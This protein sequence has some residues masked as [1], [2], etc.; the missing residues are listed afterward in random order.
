[1]AKSPPPP[2]GAG[3]S[4]TNCT[5]HLDR[6][7]LLTCIRYERAYCHECMEH[8]EAGLIC[9]ECLGLPPPEVQRR[10][11]VI[12]EVV[13]LTGIASIFGLVQLLLSSLGQIPLA[14]IGVLAGWLI[15]RRLRR[16]WQRERRS[17]V[18][19][20]GASGALQGTILAAMVVAGLGGLGIVP[21][22]NGL[23]GLGVTIALIIQ[24]TFFLVGTI[25][26][27][28]WSVTRR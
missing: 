13:F 20:L 11:L 18:L 3:S 25:A 19:M 12:R 8:G 5:V 27:L 1:M 22:G 26:G 10:N 6:E 21:L 15:G 7:T 24:S 14:L 23:S 4:A 16:Q 2:A 9:H 28:L 17:N